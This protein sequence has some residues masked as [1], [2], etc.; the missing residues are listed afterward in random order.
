MVWQTVRVFA[1]CLSKDFRDAYKGLRT[2]LMGS[3]G[4]EEPQW[5]YCIQDTNTVLGE[6]PVSV[7]WNGM[8]LTGA[9]CRFRDRRHFCP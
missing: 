9:F 8:W 3:E 1:M 5:R 6:S 4:G 7:K 2:A